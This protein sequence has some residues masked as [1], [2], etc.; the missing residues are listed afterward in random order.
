M[1]GG[2]GRGHALLLLRGWEVYG[3]FTRMLSHERTKV[4]LIVICGPV[5]EEV[6]E[7]PSLLEGSSYGTELRKCQV[8]FLGF[9]QA[10]ERHVIK[11]NHGSAG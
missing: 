6:D 8:D 9:W 3:S 10:R 4:F 5:R 2:T 11:S 1:V 7:C